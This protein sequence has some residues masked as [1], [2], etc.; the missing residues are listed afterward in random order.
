MP[1]SR[2]DRRGWIAISLA[3]LGGLVA[4]TRVIVLFRRS[5]VVDWGHVALAIGVPALMFVMVS[6]RGRG[7]ADTSNDSDKDA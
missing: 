3:V 6:A 2:I 5:G 4:F 1:S 7:G